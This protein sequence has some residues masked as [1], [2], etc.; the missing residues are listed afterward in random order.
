MEIHLEEQEASLLY[1]VIKNRL[2]EYRTAK[3]EGDMD[4]HYGDHRNQ[5][6]SNCMPQDNYSLS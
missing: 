6:I 3:D 1:R 5:G 2:N 4:P